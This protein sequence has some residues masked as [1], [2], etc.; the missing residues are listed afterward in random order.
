MLEQKLEARQKELALT[1]K[2][3]ELWR[4]FFENSPIR[5]GIVELTGNTFQ[6]YSSQLR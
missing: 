2:D 5:M 4:S 6:K 1:M 3:C